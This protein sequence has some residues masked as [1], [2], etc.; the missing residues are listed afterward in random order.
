MK[1]SALA[2]HLSTV[3]SNVKTGPIAVSTSSRA[4]CSPSCPFFGNGCYAESGPLLLHWRKVTEGLRGV[5][6]PAFL[7]SLKN[8][9]SGRLFRHN[10][11]GDLPHT[12]GRISRAFIK[13]MVASVKHLKAFTYTH[14]DIKLGENLQLLKYANRNGFTINVSTESEAAAD[15]AI[16]AGLPA[17]MVAN[18]DETRTTWHTPAGN[19]V[20]VCPA[21]RSDTTTC[22]DCK[23]CHHRGRR[24]VIAFL[25]HGTGK[26]KANAAI[27]PTA[28]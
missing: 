15:D 12:A 1:L 28:V 20:L 9:E 25:A 21:Q 27:A 22:A 19:T 10:Q 13:G 8:L 11:A 2:F 14:H 5:S 18:S 7:L 6:F 16:A 3:S 4:T 23:L 24:V 17:V 26:R